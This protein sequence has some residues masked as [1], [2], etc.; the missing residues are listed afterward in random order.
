MSLVGNK[1]LAERPELSTL[2][3]WIELGRNLRDTPDSEILSLIASVETYLEDKLHDET[4]PNADYRE[5]VGGY[6][7]TILEAVRTELRKR[8]LK[9]IG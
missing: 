9:R 2:G 6:A 3:E 5:Y 8:N 4:L 1:W 7:E